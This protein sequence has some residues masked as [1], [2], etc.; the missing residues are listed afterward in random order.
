MDKGII[1]V[2]LEVLRFFGL[3]GAYSHSS[4][5]SPCLAL[6][7]GLVSKAELLFKDATENQGRGKES[8][9]THCGRVEGGGIFNR[10]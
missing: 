6:C 3:M 4:F 9:E 1:R 2:V 8:S 5:S 7:L 10:I